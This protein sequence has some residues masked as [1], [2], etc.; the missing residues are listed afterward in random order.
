[1]TINNDIIC[2]FR[3]VLFSFYIQI[4]IYVPEFIWVGIVPVTIVYFNRKKGVL[5]NLYAVIVFPLMASWSTLRYLNFLQQDVNV[6]IISWK[7][8]SY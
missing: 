6:K 1:M 7:V 8:I 5:L 4:D 3:I 2:E